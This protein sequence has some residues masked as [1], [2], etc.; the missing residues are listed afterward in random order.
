MQIEIGAVLDEAVLEAIRRTLEAETAAFASGAATAGGH[1]RAVKRNEQAK[2][3]AADA[4]IENV[5]AALLVH[6]VFKAAARPKQLVR[7]LVS[8]YRP[9]MEYGS[10]IDDA[11]IDSQRTDLSFTL[12]L[13]DPKTYDGGELVIEANDGESAIKLAAGHLFLYPTTSLHRVNAVTRGERLAVVGWVRS[14]LRSAG[15]RE[16][17][18]DLDNAIAALR[19]TGAERA[20][21]DRLFKVRA[22]LLRM[23]VED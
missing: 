3:G 21:V 5:K 12:F 1:A 20:I 11:L 18:F 4:V 6:P 23:W 16:L 2:G 8:R 9:G 17:L 7:L 10:H 15:Q 13:N 19:Q 14:L 22:N